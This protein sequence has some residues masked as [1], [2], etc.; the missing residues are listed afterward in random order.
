MKRTLNKAVWFFI[1]AIAAYDIYYSWQWRQHL[2][3]I[4]CNPV[5]AWIFSIGGIW[6]ALVYRASWLAFAG[7]LTQTQTRFSSYIT[8]AWALGHAVLA[9]QYGR[10]LLF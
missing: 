9:V 10:L 2:L 3:E 5:A 4:E 6:C 8:P 7:I 1:L